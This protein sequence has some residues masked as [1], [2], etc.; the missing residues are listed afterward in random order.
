M[1][2]RLRQKKNQHNK[3]EMNTTDRVI[4]YAEQLLESSPNYQQSMN[5]L[6]GRVV[7]QHL[8]CKAEWRAV[9]DRLFLGREIV[10]RLFPVIVGNNVNQSFV[11]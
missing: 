1:R 5:G 2:L 6:A 4:R 10:G 7:Q 8:D 3:F 9:Q 11:R